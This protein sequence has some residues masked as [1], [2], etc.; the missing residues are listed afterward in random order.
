[1]LNG[2]YGDDILSGGEGADKFYCGYGTDTITDF[3]AT[4]G[5][6]KSGDCENF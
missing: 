5:D 6:T 3:S 4:D 2:G 1:M